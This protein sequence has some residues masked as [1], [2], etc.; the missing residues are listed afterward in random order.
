MYKAVGETEE[1]FRRA[2]LLAK[3]FHLVGDNVSNYLRKEVTWS[4]R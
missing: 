1:D 2:L 3:S 4:L